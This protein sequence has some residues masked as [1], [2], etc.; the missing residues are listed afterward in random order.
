MGHGTSPQPAS[1]AGRAEVIYTSLARGD[2]VGETMALAAQGLADAVAASAAFVGELSASAGGRTDL[3]VLGRTGQPRAGAPSLW[4]QVQVGLVLPVGAQGAV[5]AAGCLGQPW[6]RGR[7]W[8]L[9]LRIGREV[10]GV[11][12]LSGVSVPDDEVPAA[13]APVLLA[14]A[15]ALVNGREEERLAAVRAEA[16]RRARGLELITAL[17]RD[18]LTVS[19]E[20]VDQAIQTALEVIGRYVDADRSYAFRI[21]P[22][23]GIMVNTH[24]WCADGERPRIQDLQRLPLEA[25]T[26]PMRELVAGRVVDVRDVETMPGERSAEQARLLAQGIRATVMVP[27]LLRGQL[28]GMVGFD[29]VHGRRRWNSADVAIL[30]GL[31]SVV[32]H[33]QERLALEGAMRATEAVTHALGALTED[34][35][36]LRAVD[37]PAVLYVNEAFQRLTGLSPAQTVRDPFL[38]LSVVHPDDRDRVRAAAREQHH[39]LFDEIYRVVRPDGSVRHVH[40]RSFPLPGAHGGS[41]RVVGI[42]Q[43]ITERVSRDETRHQAAKMAALG[44]LAGGVAH[45][46]NNNL[47]VILGYANLSLGLVSEGDELRANLDRILRAGERSAHL[48]RQL[49]AFSRK[50]LVRPERVELDL[51]VG[52]LGRMLR[53]LLG[54]DVRLDLALDAP[55]VT[56]LI[57]PGSLDQV[58]MNLAVNARDAMPRGGVLHIRTCRERLERPRPGRW[59]DEPPAGLYAVV[60]VHDTG[61]GMDE[62]TLG[63]LFEPFFTTKGP[64]KGTGLGLST[65][66]GVVKQAGG[67]VH[68]SSEPGL[69]SRFSVLLPLAELPHA[70]ADEAGSRP[71]EERPGDRARVLVVDDDEGV[72]EVM[73]RTLRAAGHDVWMASGAEVA[74]QLVARGDLHFDLVVTDVIMPDVNGVQLAERIHARNPSLPILFV[75]G[76]TDD[77]TVQHGLRHETHAVLHKPF[78][79]EALT[80]QVSRMLSRSPPA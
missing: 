18:F 32:A 49:L 12:G 16:E 51:A 60:E 79:P 66:Y 24:E 47:M 59:S 43:D 9:P 63:R 62:P 65:V 30:E 38:Y 1:S 41:V 50:Q 72:R 2:D 75:T 22:S 73:V 13:L 36:Y 33:A 26:W 27:T 3:L 44:T 70:G 5:H 37:P 20:H 74:E 6:Q 29:S 42:A 4:Q 52:D 76:Y 71:S 46:F 78:P 39:R 80:R 45:D 7:E 11:V 17:S 8:L 64:G 77:A 25:S 14:T 31:G 57:D 23:Q 34:V 67:F 61:V 35:I 55:G 28:V 53:R 68:V 15:Q 40:D 10:V 19:V 69:G 56:L 54:E 48:T 21:D 58:L